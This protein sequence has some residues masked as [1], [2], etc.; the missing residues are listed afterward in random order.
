MSTHFH[1]VGSICVLLAVYA[2]V[3]VWGHGAYAIGGNA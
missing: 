1:V 2:S 3:I